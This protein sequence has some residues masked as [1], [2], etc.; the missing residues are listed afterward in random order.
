M[1]STRAIF[2]FF[3]WGVS[4]KARVKIIPAR[5]SAWLALLPPSAPPSPVFL[6]RR[7]QWLRLNFFPSSSPDGRPFR[8]RAR[9][10]CSVALHSARIVAE[11]KEAGTRGDT[12]TPE[13]ISVSFA[14]VRSFSSRSPQSTL[15]EH[16]YPG[17]QQ[18]K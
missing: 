2:F 5:N 6:R 3:Y 14:F 17:S 13:G 16:S 1:Y 4:G 8:A 12:Q 9:P 10:A 18:R 11:A 15:L 7:K